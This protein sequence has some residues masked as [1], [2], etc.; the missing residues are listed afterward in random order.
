MLQVTAKAASGAEARFTVSL[1][2]QLPDPN[3]ATPEPT[4]EITETAAAAPTEA[5]AAD[6]FSFSDIGNTVEGQR[7]ADELEYDGEKSATLGGNLEE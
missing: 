2:T 4:A 6:A 3:A 5:P 1:V 7:S